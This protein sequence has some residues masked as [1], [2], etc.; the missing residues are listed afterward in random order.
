[1]I[2]KTP[3]EIRKQVAAVCRS[4]NRTDDDR[5]EAEIFSYQV[6]ARRKTINCKTTIHLEYK[7]KWESTYH[8]IHFPNLVEFLIRCGF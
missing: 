5:V 4:L 1:M 3:T 2:S 6:R 7:A 8:E